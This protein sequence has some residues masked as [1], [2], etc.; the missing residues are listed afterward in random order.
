MAQG[1][2]GGG[3]PDPTAAEGPSPKAVANVR[4][5]LLQFLEEPDSEV[6]QALEALVLA[7]L[8]QHLAQQ[9]VAQ[10]LQALDDDRVR[11]ALAAVPA[12]E[13]LDA[14]SARNVHELI[15]T[16]MRNLLRPDSFRKPRW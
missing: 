3:T 7:T 4:V 10:F 9:F 15:E 8:G 11:K 13:V 6:R 12:G 14:E 2:A 1:P 16:K 5:A